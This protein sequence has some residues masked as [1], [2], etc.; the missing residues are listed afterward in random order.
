MRNP[1]P[2]VYLSWPAP[3]Y[4]DPET[5]GP[6]LIVV[7]AVLVV[8]S[9]LIVVLRLYTR[10]VLIR[11]PGP[12]DWLIGASTVNRDLSSWCTPIA[13]RYGWGLHIW[14]NRPEWYS[15]SRLLS[16]LCQITFL[17]NSGLIKSSILLSYLRIAP[18]K[19]FRYSVYVSLFF[20]AG[21][22]VGVGVAIIFTCS[23]VHGYW[24]NTVKSKCVKDSVMLLTGSIIN[25]SSDF[26]VA[27]LPAPMLMRVW[28]PV[29]QKIILLTIPGYGALTLI[30]GAVETDI[31]IATASI[32]AL[33]PL[34]HHYFP[35]MLGTNRSA[36]YDYGSRGAGAYQLRPPNKKP[37]NF[38]LYPLSTIGGGPGPESQDRIAG[39]EEGRGGLGH[40]GSVESNSGTTCEDKDSRAGVDSL[41]DAPAKAISGV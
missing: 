37:Q 1:P 9:F 25:T 31:G 6:M 4:V 32:P 26:W 40:R 20:V 38:S 22:A 13:T 2:E 19:C 35:Y 23:P 11:S 12:D 27:F 29:R 18:N 17:V 41:R 3:N 5:R 24:D 39:A 16:W 7:P 14:D 15:D 36:D 34:L 28:L 21:Y 10:F 33:R 30:W 8:I